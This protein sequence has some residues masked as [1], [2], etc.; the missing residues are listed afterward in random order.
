MSLATMGPQRYHVAKLAAAAGLAPA[1]AWEGIDIDDPT[2]TPLGIR[3][4]TPKHPRRTP[5]AGH[6]K[7]VVAA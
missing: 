6:A 4:P 1:M 7:E 3:R 5:G 2:T